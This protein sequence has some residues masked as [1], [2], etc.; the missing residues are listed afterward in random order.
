MAGVMIGAVFVWNYSRE[1]EVRLFGSLRGNT[2]AHD[3]GFKPLRRV[4]T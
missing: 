1:N 3:S 4:Y 2:Y